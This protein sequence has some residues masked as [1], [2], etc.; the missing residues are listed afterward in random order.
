MKLSVACSRVGYT[1]RGVISVGPCKG[2]AVRSGTVLWERLAVVN[3]SPGG[4]HRGSRLLPPPSSSVYPAH[5]PCL[6]H[7]SGRVTVVWQSCCDI[8]PPF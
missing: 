6:Q 3:E 8:S 1:V 5:G 4:L 2:W 7:P